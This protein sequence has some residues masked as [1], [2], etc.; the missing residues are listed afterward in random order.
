MF[1]W[2]VVTCIYLAL[3]TGVAE[4]MGWWT[5]KCAS[6]NHAQLWFVTLNLMLVVPLTSQ[7]DIWSIDIPAEARLISSIQ[8]LPRYDESLEDSAE[9]RI[10][11]SVTA[12]LSPEKGVVPALQIASSRSQGFT[13]QWAS[14]PILAISIYCLGGCWVAIRLA[15]VAFRHWR[16]WQSASPSENIQVRLDSIAKRYL[17]RSRLVVRTH[18]QVYSPVLIGWLRPKLLV[19]SGFDLWA[20][21]EQAAVLL[22]E[23]AHTK[24]LDHLKQAVL[25]VNSILLWFHPASWWCRSRYIEARE[26]AA[27]EQA[28]HWSVEETGSGNASNYPSALLAAASRLGKPIG[29]VDSRAALSMSGGPVLE[30]RLSRVLNRNIKRFSPKLQN[31]ISLASLIILVA[32]VSTTMI[33]FVNTPVEAQVVSQGRTPADE[34]GRYRENP[35]PNDLPGTNDLFEHLDNA[36]V[37][38]ALRDESESITVEGRVADTEGNECVGCTV[39]LFQK[40]FLKVPGRNNSNHTRT[41]LVAKTKASPEGDYRFESTRLVRVPVEEQSLHLHSNPYLIVLAYKRGAGFV[42]EYLPWPAPENRDSVSR[43]R[44]EKD[45]TLRSVVNSSGNIVG[46]NA[47]KFGEKYISLLSANSY[48][49][50]SR[51]TIVFPTLGRGLV[52]RVDQPGNFEFKNL[53]GRVVVHLVDRLGTDSPTLMQGVWTGPDESLPFKRLFPIVKR[54]PVSLDWA[55]PD[56]L[57]VKVLNH[58]GKPSANT[59]VRMVSNLPLPQSRLGSRTPSITDD[60]GVFRLLLEPT[61]NLYPT[62]VPNRPEGVTFSFGFQDQPDLFFG[63]HSVEVPKQGSK[64]VV[65]RLG[66]RLPDS[67]FPVQAFLPN[68]EAASNAV[69]RVVNDRDSLSPSFNQLRYDTNENGIVEVNLKGLSPQRKLVVIE[70]IREDQHFFA[71]QS[72]DDLSPDQMNKIDLL[73]GGRIVGN[74][75]LNGK[76]MPKLKVGARPFEEIRTEGPV[77]GTGS[78]TFT[79]SMYNWSTT[80]DDDGRYVLWVPRG[81]RYSLHALGYPS[82]PNYGFG[83][84]MTKLVESNRETVV[85]FSGVTGDRQLRGVIIDRETREPIRDISIRAQA[86]F[87]RSTFLIRDLGRRIETV[88]NKYG[89][90]AFDG[91]ASGPYQLYVSKPKKNGIGADYSTTIKHSVSDDDDDV[92]FIEFYSGTFK[93]K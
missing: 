88:T 43:T 73:L 56:F 48:S 4:V 40:Y 26:W 42:R 90:F 14:W 33:G 86:I 67:T 89:E 1:S 30:R 23:L 27:D 11:A 50:D 55:D 29:R 10:V 19:P 32:L 2:F 20:N 61:E 18:D 52:A 66:K 84:Q 46:W 87:G 82:M 15:K 64:D 13:I 53:P 35:F 83:Q 8:D 69:C 37:S 59:R 91:L 45:L 5:R 72:L 74:T 16:Q 71:T 25:W 36:R 62:L 49:Q 24:R 31:S 9:E 80:S 12:D 17:P 76:P 28:D 7:L 21:D 54:F 81:Q 51:P 68:G 60:K 6:H 93:V 47:T 38:R 63:K 22:H 57:T 77:P 44:I 78:S 41:H 92:L 39:L 3:L 70:A 65:V 85:S 75:E 58:E 79:Y 34:L